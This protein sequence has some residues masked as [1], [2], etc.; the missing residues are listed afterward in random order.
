MRSSLSE[1]SSTGFRTNLTEAET[2][3]VDFAADTGD[4]LVLKA[5]THALEMLVHLLTTYDLGVPSGGLI[6]LDRAGELEAERVLEARF[7]RHRPPRGT[8]GLAAG[9]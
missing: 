2:G 4:A 7:Q 1:I 3:G 5:G 9:P 8:R 6:E